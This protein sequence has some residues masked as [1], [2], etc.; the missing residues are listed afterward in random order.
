MSSR[1][2][3]ALEQFYF[4]SYDLSLIVNR[5]WY[6]WVTCWFGG[7]AGVITSYRIDRSGFLLFKRSWG[8]IRLLFY[9]LFL[10]LRLLSSNHNIHYAGEIGKGLLILH[11]A[12]GIVVN[13]HI[14]AGENL[15]LTGGN[16]LGGRRKLKSGDFIIGNNVSLGANA[17]ILGPIKIGNHVSIG[18]GAVVV[19]DAPDNVVLAGVPAEIIKDLSLMEIYY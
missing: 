17:V 14:T 6:R 9:P 13:G 19:H 12:L 10:F 16:C 18:A 4:L 5:Q 8:A 1:L 15:T 2:K 11:P 3:K 7:S